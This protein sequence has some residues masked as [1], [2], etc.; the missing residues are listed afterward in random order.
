MNRSKHKLWQVKTGKFTCC[1]IAVL[2]DNL[3]KKFL[4]TFDENQKIITFLSKIWL[5]VCSGK[6]TCVGCL[7]VKWCLHLRGAKYIWNLCQRVSSTCPKF[8]MGNVSS[9]CPK[10]LMGKIFDGAKYIWNLC[11]RVSSTCPKFLMGNVSSICPKF[12]TEPNI[13][14]TFAS[15]YLPPVQNF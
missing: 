3:S 12:L 6:M 1:R 7:S 2:H 13:Y 4:E 10:L 15:V 8:L 9:T 11:Q 14:E 5:K